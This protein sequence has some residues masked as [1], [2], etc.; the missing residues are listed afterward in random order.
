[1][2]R[3]IPVEYYMTVPVSVNE[4][5]YRGQQ[6]GLADDRRETRAAR[7]LSS[8]INSTTEEEDESFVDDMQQGMRSS[9]FP[10]PVLSSIEAGVKHFHQRIQSTFPVATL[11][12][13]PVAGTVEAVN[14]DMQA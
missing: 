9:V 14:R 2:R 13:Q 1:G 8:R 11:W 4:T 7:Y 3:T 5:R 12:H 6:F 10:E